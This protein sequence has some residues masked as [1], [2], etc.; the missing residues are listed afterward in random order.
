MANKLHPFALITG[1]SG[2]LQRLGRLEAVTAATRNS[3]MSVYKLG[4]WTRAEGR[5]K[6]SGLVQVCS[7]GQKPLRRC[8]SEHLPGGRGEPSI[9]STN[10]SWGERTEVE[11]KGKNEE[12]T[13]GDRPE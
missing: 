2:R 1:W 5:Q 12:A 4:K 6:Q 3:K 8:Q 10:R 9:S 13:V 11:K 7:L